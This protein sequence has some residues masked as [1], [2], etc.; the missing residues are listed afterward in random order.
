MFN[1]TGKVYALFRR[2]V[3]LPR[4]QYEYHCSDKHDGIRMDLDVKNYLY[5]NNTVTIPAKVSE[6]PFT[7]QHFNDCPFEDMC[8]TW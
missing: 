5:D 2:A 3:D 4:N 6:G 7:V 8:D 1:T